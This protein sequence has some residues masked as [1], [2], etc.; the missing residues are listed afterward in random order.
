MFRRLPP[1]TGRQMFE[2]A[3]D[4]G[5]DAIDN[6]PDELVA[7]FEHIDN[8][9]AWITRER[10]DRGAIVANEVSPAGKASLIFLNTLATVQGGSVGDAVGTMGR[11]QRNM[12]N[13]SLESAE[14][15]LHLP[16][17][18]ALDRFGTA[19][20]NAVRV[21]L[22]HAQARVM[23]RRKWGEEWV[24][25]HG[26]PIS[27]AEMSGGIPSFGV[28]NLM[29]DINYGRHYDYR[30]LEDLN[31]FWSYIGHIMGIREAMIPRTFGEAVELLDYGYAVM[32]PPSEFSEALN[33]VSEM[34]L[35]TLMDKVRVPLID[36]QVKSAIHQTLHGLY[37]FIGGTFLGKRITGTPSRPGSDASHRNSS[38]RRRS[39]RIW[40]GASPAIGSGR[41][42]VA[43]TA[44]PAGPS[45]TTPSPSR[46]PSRTAG[47]VP[48]SPTTTS[49]SRPSAR[50][51]ERSGRGRQR[52]AAAGVRPG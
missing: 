11:M 20:K 48:P 44:T 33:E 41:T 1:R 5:L 2:N 34:M 6:P 51:A 14:F 9:P 43:P 50:P 12:I 21:R 13:R 32:E 38:P 40:T 39:S 3:L 19:F 17:P 37:F 29:Y 10:V 36:A 16:A 46:P 45:C 23:L 4:N 52:V 28:A 26:G 31:I 25:Q 22:M 24:A 7:L 42:S 47:A 30:D 35:N 8:P 27:N 15:W 49:G 18:G